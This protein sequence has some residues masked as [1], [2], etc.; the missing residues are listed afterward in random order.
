[1]SRKPI[2]EL[3]KHKEF[4]YAILEYP[5]HNYDENSSG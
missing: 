5:F 2:L 4:L 1:M 3:P